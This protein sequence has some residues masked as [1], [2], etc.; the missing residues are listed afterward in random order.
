MPS[1]RAFVLHLLL[2]AS[3]FGITFAVGYVYQYHPERDV[4]ELVVDRNADV[5]RADQQTSGTVIGIDG[6]TIRIRTEF[7]LLELQ[8]S[9]VALEGL[10]SVTDPAS[11]PAGAAVNMGGERTATERVIT[12]IVFVDEGEAQP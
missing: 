2:L 4:V 9:D 5:G 12:G 7:D 10:V 1:P 11:V 3:V 6:G 8:R